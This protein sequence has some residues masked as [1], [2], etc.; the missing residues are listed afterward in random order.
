MVMRN[1]LS[2]IVAF[3]MF[4]MLSDASEHN[5]Y[6]SSHGVNRLR[7]DVNSLHIDNDIHKNLLL[8]P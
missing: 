3:L 8:Y 6:N 1:I 4:V 2:I 7:C 5:I